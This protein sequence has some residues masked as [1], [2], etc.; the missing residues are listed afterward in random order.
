[1]K[2]LLFI[3][4]FLCCFFA[5]SLSAQ[6]SDDASQDLIRFGIKGGLNYSNVWDEQGQDFS[7]DPKFGLAGGI[8]LGIPIGKYM[9]FQPELLI[10]Q[11]GFKGSGTLLL[12]DYSFSRTTTY[13]DVPLQLF[14]MPSPYLTIVGGPQYSYL[15]HQKD[16]FTFGAN[17]VEQEQEF[18]NENV[19]KNILGFVFGLDL[20]ISRA[21]FS[22]R[23]GWDF[24]TNHGDG[25]SSTPNYK[26]R[27][28]QFTIG[29]QI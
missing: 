20:N 10:S 25:S 9:G 2:K 12:N 22:G 7:A 14:I 3:T 11:K 29:F 17:S 8:F 27:W 5:A 16:V 15:I 13:I 26:N 24:Q 4:G 23:F 19:R 6:N 18:N 1:M 28:I 21:V